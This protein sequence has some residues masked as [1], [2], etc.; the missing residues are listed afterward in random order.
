MA[1]VG[2]ILRRARTVLQERS[3]DGTRWS[4]KELLDWLNEAYAALLSI[5]PSAFATTVEMACQAGAQQAIPGGAEQLIEV[6]GT[7]SGFGVT[8]VARST[9]DAVRRR[10]Q[11][12]PQTDAIEHW[13][14]EDLNPRSFWVYPP[15]K[16]G[17]R[18]NLIVAQLP[19]RHAESE[20]SPNS[21][22][23]LRLPDAYTPIVLD[24]VLARAFAK[25]AESQANLARASLH[26]QA[27]QAAL[28]LK[29]QADAGSSPAG[30]GSA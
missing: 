20:A 12:E 4:N 16:A 30:D 19:E 6:T 7:A 15:A 28:G 11:A 25:D 21:N 2:E 29:I 5:R 18:L 17:V 27:A 3:Q 8:R 13:M 24:L 10:W 22:D 1:T 14:F 23:P 9:M 26:A